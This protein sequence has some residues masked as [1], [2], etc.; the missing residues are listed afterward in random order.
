[1][2]E[3]T[4]IMGGGMLLLIFINFF[5]K[6]WFIGLAVVILG[7]GA[8]VAMPKP[9]NVY[10]LCAVGVVVIGEVVLLITSRFKDA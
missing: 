6:S 7:V 10:L 1:M 9:L 4:L 8:I 2:N 3:Y 5:V